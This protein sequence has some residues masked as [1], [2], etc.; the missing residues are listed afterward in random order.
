MW[1]C[2]LVSNVISLILP[3]PYLVLT[4]RFTGR[5]STMGKE[6]RLGL[7]KD[8]SEVR[9]EWRV[10]YWTDD[11]G[12]WRIETANKIAHFCELF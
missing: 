6:G 4:Q 9:Q 3:R 10:S 11:D 2:F 8:R 7:P 5:M 12:S 1:K